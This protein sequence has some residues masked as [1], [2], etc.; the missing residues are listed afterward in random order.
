MNSG[1]ILPEMRSSHIFQTCEAALQAKC[2]FLIHTKRIRYVPFYAGISIL[3]GIIAM[4]ALTAFLRL[5]EL[6]IPDQWKGKYHGLI[7][8]LYSNFP[9]S[10]LVWELPLRLFRMNLSRAKL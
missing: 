4:L 8:Q 5:L 10:A 3:T 7:V 9:S 2:M 6:V 1:M